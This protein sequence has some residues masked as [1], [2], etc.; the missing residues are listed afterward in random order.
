MEP[1]RTDQYSADLGGQPIG[2]SGHW[3]WF[4]SR[5]VAR[6]VLRSIMDACAVLKAV[7]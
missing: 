5:K 1:R 6:K 2:G 3:P 4:L 7:C